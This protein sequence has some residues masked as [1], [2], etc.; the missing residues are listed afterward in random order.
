M[1][2]IFMSKTDKQLHALR[3]QQNK[4]GKEARREIQR[5]KLVGYCDGTNIQRIV[6]EQY[7]DEARK[8]KVEIQVSAIHE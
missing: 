4:E 8:N 6:E 5:R 3:F 7:N 2:T 1:Q